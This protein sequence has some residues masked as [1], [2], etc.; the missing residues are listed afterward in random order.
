M[1]DIIESALHC[2]IRE[3]RLAD[4]RNF[5]QEAGQFYGENRPEPHAR[6][7]VEMAFGEWRLGRPDRARALAEEAER[8]LA[9]ASPF[10]RLAFLYAEMGEQA[11]VRALL[12]EMTAH[13]PQATL[14]KLWRGVAEA[15]TAVSRKDAKAALDLLQPL[16]RF[17]LRYGDVTLTRAK[18]HVAAGN[19]VAAIADFKRI[20]DFPPAG[21]AGSVYPVALISLARARLAAGD[22]TGAKAAYD[23]FLDLW[24]DADADL[25][26]LADARRERAALQ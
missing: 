10:H 21:P 17:E 2:G 4:A 25:Q 22:V 3:G 14:L 23:Q 11:R 5:L 6:L 18:A 19:S 24:K 15:T 9:L 1:P 20:V 26:L 13:Q 8:M 7:M 12:A 16:Q